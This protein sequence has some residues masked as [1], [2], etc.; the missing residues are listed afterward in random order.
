MGFQHSQQTAHKIRG[1]T[2]AIAS[3]DTPAHLKPHL[4]QKLKEHQAM[5]IR[6]P[7]I[8]THSN[9]AAFAPGSG[10]G[11]KKNKGQS[12][13]QGNKVTT[14][15]KA[16]MFSSSP[17]VSPQSKQIQSQISATP[18]PFKNAAGILKPVPSASIEAAPGP[19]AKPAAG[20]RRVNSVPA[21]PP[22]GPV[23]GFKPSTLG[24]TVG[25]KPAKRKVG[26]MNA[27]SKKGGHS[28]LYGD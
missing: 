6:N 13:P 26:N 11:P 12:E 27:S 17:M 8:G 1:I 21:N 20:L 22:V 15:S 16:N 2:Q 28:L 4:R 3:P 10:I 14:G 5:A 7:N 24:L 25:V 23:G 9:G 19:V 18:A